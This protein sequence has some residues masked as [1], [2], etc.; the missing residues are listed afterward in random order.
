MARLTVMPETLEAEALWAFCLAL[1][2]RSEVESACLTLQ[3]AHGFDV[4]IVLFCLYAGKSGRKIDSTTLDEA[5]TIGREWGREIVA[6]LR[7]TRRKLK[8]PTKGVDPHDAYR[9]RTR[10]QAIEQDAERIQHEQLCKLLKP[11]GLPPSR[12]AARDNLLAYARKLNIAPPPAFEVLLTA[13]F[14]G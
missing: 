2:A 10:I 1:Y 9:L 7:L 14:P 3:D 4:M 11:S 8:T 5:V 13:A 6:P 12:Q